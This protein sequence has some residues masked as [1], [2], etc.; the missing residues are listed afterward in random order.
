MIKPGSHLAK[1]LA[2]FFLAL[3]FVLC[4]AEKENIALGKSYTSS[5]KPNAFSNGYDGSPMCK[6]DGDM[7]QLTDGELADSCWWDK[8]T[9][10]WWHEGEL[11]VTI[12]LQ[13]VTPVNEIEIHMYSEIEGY[14]VPRKLVVFVSDD[15]VN[16]HP[17]AELDKS[18]LLNQWKS[19]MAKS[20][21]G[22]MGAWLKVKDLKTKGRYVTLMF[23][24]VNLYLDEV[25]IFSGD[26]KAEDIKIPDNE[27]TKNLDLYPFYKTNKGYVANNLVLPFQLNTQN[28]IDFILDLPPEISLVAP[29]PAGKIEKVSFEGQEYNRYTIKKANCLFMKSSLPENAEKK[30]RIENKTASQIITAQTVKI[31]E[32]KAFDK[33]MTGIGF[34]GYMY[35]EKWPDAVENYSK[36]G[37]NIFSVFQHT[38]YYYQL[39]NRENPNIFR[40]IAKA[41]EKGLKIGGDF[42][43]F[44]AIGAINKNGKNAILLNGKPANTGCPRN[45][46]KSFDDPKGELAQAVAGAKAGVDIFFFDSEPYWP[47]PICACPACENEWKEFLSRKAPDLPHKTL[48]ATYTGKDNVYMPLMQEFW[49]EFYCKLWGT[50]K[51]KMNKAAGKN[52]CLALYDK[53]LK[54]DE[55]DGSAYLFGNNPLF[56]SLYNR[57][58][59]DCAN[60]SLYLIPTEKFGKTVKKLRKSLPPAAPLYLWITAGSLDIMFERTPADLRNRL[61]EL[62]FNGAQG[63]YFWNAYGVDACD[64]KVIAEVI[65]DLG[66]Y[67]PFFLNGQLMDEKSFEL[68]QGVNAAGIKLGREAVLLISRYQNVPAQITVTIGNSIKNLPL[69]V[70]EPIGGGEKQILKDGKFEV[71]FSGDE[72]DYVKIFYLHP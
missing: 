31:P 46:L 49:D 44:C 63:F 69:R 59:V 72:K 65:R 27:W 70:V 8:R 51:E 34:A 35:W 26:L 12:D 64:Y 9:V 4:S 24:V 7:I 13:N 1:I 20:K 19:G 57:N 56:L 50:F 58:I 33:L 5:K 29:V 10:G 48:V 52:V 18:E 67:E 23:S 60:P 28:G 54:N 37:L 3:S 21:D 14:R 39:I 32:V 41:R 36:T 42:S 11:S 45:Y 53:P 40:L 71:G 16:F 68:P 61:L 17:A 47:G 38:D 6:D 2:V 66:P 22:N 25:K 62:F 15:N 43:P 30:I 55:A